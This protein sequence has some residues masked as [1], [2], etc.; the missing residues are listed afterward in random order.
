[1]P[2]GAAAEHQAPERGV[3][4]VP[5]PGPPDDGLVLRAGERDVREPE[6]LPTLL[7]LV[8]AA[9]VGE[10]DAAHADVDDALVAARRVVEEDRLRVARDVP[11]LPQVRE[12]HD[13]ELE[14]LAAVDGEHLDRLG[15]GLQ[16]AAA[17]LVGR[18]VPGV[19]DLPA[20]PRGERG[21]AG[22]L[23]HRRL[24]QQLG[25]VAQV[26]QAP[27]AVLGAQH[28][29]GQALD[30]RDRLG[31]RGDPTG[32]QQPRPGVQP[33]VQLLDR[34]LVGG[35]QVLGAPA[36]ERRQRR[37][38]C[39]RRVRRALQRL[40]QPQPVP[41]RRRAEDAARAVDDGGDAGGLQRVADERGVAVRAHEDRDVPGAHALAPDRLARVVA[42]LD[43]RLGR[44][45]GRRGRPRGPWRCARAR[46]RC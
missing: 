32:P 5:R 11:G 15:V 12:Q 16:A 22:V 3:A 25:D 30:E 27:L 34:L 9:V 44:A 4:A 10:V 6:V 35:R 28:A 33:A 38:A 2:S 31:E 1:M 8:L 37:R 43:L 40:Q 13:R 46:T 17:L 14:A 41:R 45:G 36:E 24:V 21:D 26:G 42:D 19:G 39:P 18:V 29:L 7:G 20:Q 23:G